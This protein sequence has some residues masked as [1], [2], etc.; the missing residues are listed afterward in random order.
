M[1]SLPTRGT[2]R[3]FTAS[4]ATQSQFQHWTKPG[5]IFVLIAQRRGHQLAL[6]RPM[7]NFVLT[8]ASPELPVTNNGPE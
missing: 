2:S 7:R 4:W 8:T 1:V 6:G 3:R 5:N